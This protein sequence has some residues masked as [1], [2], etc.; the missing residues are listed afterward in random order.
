MRWAIVLLTLAS[1]LQR[2]AVEV[3]RPATDMQRPPIGKQ[4]PFSGAGLP[5]T[6][7]FTEA[8]AFAKWVYPATPPDTNVIICDPGPPKLVW[9]G[10]ISGGLVNLGYFEFDY[11]THRVNEYNGASV[12]MNS[13]PLSD[14]GIDACY[15]IVQPLCPA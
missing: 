11:V 3:Q 6:C 10:L 4:R 7:P 12:L 15:A 2:P 14:V 9:G 8:Y 13:W 1:I 5:S